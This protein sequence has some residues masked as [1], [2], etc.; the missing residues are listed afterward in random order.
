[1]NSATP[2][3]YILVPILMPETNKDRLIPAMENTIGKEGYGL[4]GISIKEIRK[5]LAANYAKYNPK[6]NFTKQ[7]LKDLTAK[8]AEGLFRAR[9][10][11]L[12]RRAAQSKKPAYFIYIER[13][14]MP[15]NIHKAL[16]LI[17]E[18]S[19]QINVNIVALVPELDNSRITY[20]AR[21]KT[22]FNPF[23]LNL[24]FAGLKQSLKKKHEVMLNGA[25]SSSTKAFLY[26]FNLFA[27]FSLDEYSLLQKG[28]DKVLYMPFVNHQNQPVVPDQLI[29]ALKGAL[30]TCEPG[31]DNFSPECMDELRRIYEGLNVP[32]RVAKKEDIEYSIMKFLE[33]EVYP[34]IQEKGSQPSEDIPEPI[35]AIVI[36]EQAKPAPRKLTK[37]EKRREEKERKRAEKMGNGS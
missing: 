29:E 22:Y 23:P 30:K 13:D 18:H 20:E 11:K 9:L 33:V 2:P 7:Q 32:V 5:E 26:F 6:E 28:F 14:H 15:Q 4:K 36:Q 12:I 31:K 21:G 8:D 17:K 34:N 24:V 35:E 3:I 25:M 37:V 10:G 1:M 16:R 19:E 27:N